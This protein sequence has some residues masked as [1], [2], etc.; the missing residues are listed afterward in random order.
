MLG[1]AVLGWR[2]LRDLDAAIVEGRSMVPT[3]EPGDRLVV[4]SWTYRQ[5]PPRPGEVVLAADPRHPDRE[6][7]KRVAAV[8]PESLTLLGDGAGSTDSRTF[9]AVPLEAVRWRAVARYWPPRRAG[10]IPGPRRVSG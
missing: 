6:L 3:L 9:G 4:E 1:V 7:A 2:V 8:G 5:R 10:R